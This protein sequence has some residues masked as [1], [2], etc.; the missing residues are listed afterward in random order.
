MLAPVAD[1]G[2]ACLCSQCVVRQRAETVSVRLGGLNRKPQANLN[3]FKSRV[4]RSEAPA[5]RHVYMTEWRS[6]KMPATQR[7]ATL[8]IADEALAANGTLLS[9]RALYKQQAKPQAQENDERRRHKSF[10][11]RLR[12]ENSGCFASCAS[13]K[14]RSKP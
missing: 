8:V 12:H 4:L 6:L 10:S 1:Q 13:S 14:P 11:A 5:Q 3:G 2:R 7:G 9:S